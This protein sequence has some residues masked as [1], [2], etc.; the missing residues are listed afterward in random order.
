VAVAQPA[1]AHAAEDVGEGDEA[2][3]EG[4]ERAPRQQAL[5][6][7][8]ASRGSRATDATLDETAGEAGRRGGAPFRDVSTAVGPTLD[9]QPAGAGGAAAAAALTDRPAAPHRGLPRNWRR[10]RRNAP[11]GGAEQA[12]FIDAEGRPRP[13]EPAD[14]LGD[15][16]G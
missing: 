3:E 5:D 9:G 10:N 7:V 8:R 2:G 16:A 12:S 15:A 6:R 13:A 11:P 14:G 4:R 1:A